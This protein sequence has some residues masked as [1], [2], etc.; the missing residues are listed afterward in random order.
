MKFEYNKHTK[1]FTLELHGIIHHLTKKQAETLMRTI[2]IELMES[3]P[4][5]QKWAEEE[6]RKAE[7]E[8]KKHE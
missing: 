7:E 3:D 8:A 4:E 1:M 6:S 2:E 5:F